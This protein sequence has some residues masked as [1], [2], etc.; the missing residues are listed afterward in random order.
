[1]DINW[2]KSWGIILQPVHQ[3]QTCVNVVWD[4]RQV[5][6]GPWIHKYIVEQTPKS[7]ETFLTITPGFSL[8]MWASA[9]RTMKDRYVPHGR[10]P[11][12]GT[13]GIGGSR[14]LNSKVPH[15]RC[16]STLTNQI[17]RLA[18][19][20]TLDWLWFPTAKVTWYVGQRPFLGASNSVGGRVRC[21]AA[22]ETQ[23]SMD[24]SCGFNPVN[25]N[26]TWI[27][28]QDQGRWQPQQY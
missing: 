3:N 14:F 11:V 17:W 23:S 13:I 7:G 20:T 28:V 6:M 9:S 24:R 16:R 1:M 10:V 26:G 19:S 8:Y 18:R 5:H 25:Q 22:H 2:G 12:R 27:S 4:T 15:A 21:L